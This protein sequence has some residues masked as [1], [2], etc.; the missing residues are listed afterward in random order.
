MRLKA[1]VLQT[2]S[3][4]SNLFGGINIILKKYAKQDTQAGNPALTGA[5]N[6]KLK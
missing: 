1:N 3:I 6:N 2:Q 4:I 5:P